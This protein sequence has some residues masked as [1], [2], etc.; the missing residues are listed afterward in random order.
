FACGT[1]E[2]LGITAAAGIAIAHRLLLGEPASNSDRLL[3]LFFMLLAG[4]LEGSILAYFQYRLIGKIFPEIAWKQWLAYTIAA[5][6]SAWML[7]MLPSLFLTENG[8]TDPGMEPAPLIFYSMAALMGLLL[9]ALFGYF[10]WLTL[11]GLRKEAMLWI[12]ANALGWAVGMVFI[13]LGASWPDTSTG[14]PLILLAGALG[15]I[16]GG[17]SVG[18]VTGFFLLRIA[19]S[20][21]KRN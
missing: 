9:G 14:W 11:K 2:F 13:F 15:G 4:A 21:H 6:I 12:P 8:A 16:T 3:N 20:D 7:G 1:G 18:A 19:R 10:Q 5:A 17:L